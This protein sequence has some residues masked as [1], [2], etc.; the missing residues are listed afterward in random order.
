M[1][2]TGRDVQEAARAIRGVVVETPC[3]YSRTLSEISGARVFLKFEP[4]TQCPIDTRLVDARM[5]SP[6]EHDWLNG[7]HRRVQRVLSPHL[8]AADRRWLKAAC[9][10]I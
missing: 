1:S 6:A 3:L 4:L 10:P 2:V 8:D 7:Y 9:A 5:L